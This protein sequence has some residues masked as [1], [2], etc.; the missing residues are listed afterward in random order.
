MEPSDTLGAVGDDDSEEAK[1][2]GENLVEEQRMQRKS[3]V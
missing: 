1:E 3:P 2:L